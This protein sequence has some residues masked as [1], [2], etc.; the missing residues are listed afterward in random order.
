MPLL[1]TTHEPRVPTENTKESTKLR[2]L[3]ASVT[4]FALAA[5]FLAFIWQG[6]DVADAGYHLTQQQLFITG[7]SAYEYDMIWLSHLSGAI[8]MKLVGN[9]GLIGARIGWVL[10]LATTGCVTFWILSIYYQPLLS[11][12]ATLATAVA[13]NYRGQ[14]LINYYTLP[15]LLLVCAVGFLLAAQRRGLIDRRSILYCAF[16]GIVLGLAVMARFP[17]ISSLTLAFV[18][19]TVILIIRKEFDRA[20]W[21]QG[22]VT[23]LFAI[24]SMSLCLTALYLTNHLNEYWN[25]FTFMKQG[26]EHHSLRVMIRG[27]VR[28]FISALKVIPYLFCIVFFLAAYLNFNVRKYFGV[29]PTAILFGAIIVS[30]VFCTIVI[31][32]GTFAIEWYELLLPGASFVAALICMMILYYCKKDAS[33]QIVLLVVGTSLPVFM[34]AGTNTGVILSYQALWL[35]LPTVFIVLPSALESFSQAV[36]RFKISRSVAFPYVMA[37]MCALAL[38]GGGFRLINSYRDSRNRLELVHKIDHSQLKC[39]FTSESRAKSLSECLRELHRRVDEGDVIL[40]YNYIPMFYYL[41]KTAPALRNPWPVLPLSENTLRK[42]INDLEREQSF[43]AVVVRAKTNPRYRSWGTDEP[44]V[45]TQSFV[46]DKLIMIDEA[47]KRWGY[48][49]VWSN[50]DF[51]ILERTDD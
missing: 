30:T 50:R 20:L 49:E 37:A 29:V 7:S 31:Y 43:P 51:I 36:F 14:M 41:T 46:R 9:L 35:V 22:A 23:F 48:Q 13:I 2:F 1:S 33:D 11:F 25:I 34:I 47:V 10:V 6:I 16:S 28:H 3:C 12:I 21:T 40:A 45:P 4:I 18:P 15:T 39:I 26:A 19:A 44:I 17:L 5:Y 38:C 32:G 27:Y 42:R 8:W 24:L